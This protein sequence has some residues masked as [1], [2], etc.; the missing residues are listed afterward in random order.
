Y[1]GEELPEDFV[2]PL[3]KHPASDFSKL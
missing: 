3:C 2:C 1:E